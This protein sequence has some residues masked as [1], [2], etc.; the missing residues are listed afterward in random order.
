MALSEAERKKCVEILLNADKTKKQAVQLSTTY[1]HIT[2]EDS[3]AIST[4]VAQHKIKG[5]AKLIGHKVGLTSKAMQASSQINEPDY[6]HL[7]D[8]MMIPDGAQV[9]HADYCLPRGELD[10]D[11]RQAVVGVLHLRAVGDHH[12]VQQMAVVG[13]VDLG[14]GLHRLR[15]QPDFMADQ[16]RAPFDLVLRDRGG[17]RVGVLDGDVGVGRR[18]LHRLLLRL[19]GV[20]QDLDALLPFCF[21]QRHGN[22]SRFG[23]VS[24][25]SDSTL[26]NCSG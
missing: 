15:G 26:P 7:L 12:I 3:Y 6:G 10:L 13:L 25:R 22:L 19:V 2:I 16:L 5:G 14:R 4:A 24:T 8:Y 17:D 20:Q 23:S 1:P 11:A 9:Q 21:G 18:Q